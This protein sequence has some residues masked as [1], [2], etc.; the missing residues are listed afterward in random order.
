MPKI[1][2]IIIYNQD[3]ILKT[4]CKSSGDTLYYIIMRKIIYTDDVIRSRLD[5]QGGDRIFDTGFIVREY[6]FINKTA[7]NID[8]INPDFE[9]AIRISSED[10]YAED[11]IDSKKYRTPYPHVILK[12]PGARHRYRTRA[13]RRGFF[14]IM[15]PEMAEAAVK[16]GFSM[17]EPIWP[18]NF[19]PE[20][21]DIISKLLKLAH[22]ISEPLMRERVEFLFSQLFFELYAAR[23]NEP[24]RPLSLDEKLH[25]IKLFLLANDTRQTDLQAEIA[26]HGL[27]RSTFYRYWKKLYGLSP[28][29]MQR[30]HLMDRAMKM[31]HQNKWTIAE[32]ARK[33]G[34]EDISYFSRCFRKQFGC[35]PSSARSFP[36]ITVRKNRN[37]PKTVF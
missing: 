29:A 7:V 3:K 34:F 10:K 26:A 2:S 14:F 27:P 5:L 1:N 33:L 16:R 15:P 17:Q 21:E 11:E 32:T 23:K 25:Q 37:C 20:I 28:E 22:N 19:S 18:I 13:P 6:G 8:R 24:E 9:V 12:L 31:L 35:S 30:Q 4:I 36:D